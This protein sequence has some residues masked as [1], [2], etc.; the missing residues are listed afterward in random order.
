MSEPGQSL[1]REI[2][3]ALAVDSSTD[4][5][6]RIR[7]RISAMPAPVSFRW[8]YLKLGMALATAAILV[9]A[10]LP[11]PT[12]KPALEVPPR[13]EVLHGNV[14]VPEPTPP[15]VVP[16]ASYRKESTPQTADISGHDAGYET[17]DDSE[18][19]YVSELQ[20]PPVPAFGLEVAP[21]P[22]MYIAASGNIDR[23]AIEPFSLSTPQSGVEE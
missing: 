1:E 4:L 8:W 3:Q 6:A 5:E 19:F 14:P 22:E 2:E 11:F 10:I 18:D 9:A 23:M 13:A 7:R 17:H 21:L 12:D 16:S 15:V 20:A